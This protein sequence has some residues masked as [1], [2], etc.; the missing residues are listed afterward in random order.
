MGE[1]AVKT[2]ILHLKREGLVDSVRAGS[3]LTKK[4]VKFVNEFLK[5]ISSEC[6]L[7][8]S[9]LTQS[10]NNYAVLLRNFRSQI[11]SGLE[12]R[13]GAILYG[14]TGA[15]TMVY[16]KNKFVFPGEEKDCL[17]SDKEVRKVLLETLRPKEGDVI[18]LASAS[19]PFSAEIAAKNSAL[20]T[21]SH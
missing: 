9:N 8:S 16:Q 5:V 17:L 1:G 10:K 4:G 18:I 13:D 12:Q 20:L 7:G 6:F 15:M 21:I 14:A 3:F 2:L 11:R 19:N